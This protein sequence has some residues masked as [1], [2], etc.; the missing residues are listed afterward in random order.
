VKHML[1]TLLLMASLPFA[2]CPAH[3]AQPGATLAQPAPTAEPPAAQAGEAQ[4]WKG[5]LE[6]PGMKLEFIALLTPAHA[7]SPASGTLDIPMQGLKDGPLSEVVVTG[8]RIAFVLALPQMPPQN[9]ARFTA[10]P[11][12]DGLSARGELRQSGGVFPVSLTRIAADAQVGPVRPQEPKPPFPYAQRDVTYINAKDGTTLAGTLT[13]PPGDGPHPAVILITGS[14]PQDRDETIFGHKPFWVLA[15]HLSRQGI[16]VLRV[17]DR[18]VGGSSG[19]TMDSTADD[20][21]GDVLAAVALLRKQPEIDAKRIGV[22]GHS[23]GGLV[24]PI[25]ASQ[26]ADIAFVVMLA[27]TGIKGRDILTLQ[28]GTIMRASGIAQEQVLAVT[29]KHRALMDLLEQQAPREEIIAATKALINS[30][31]QAGGAGPMSDAELAAMAEQAVASMENTWFRAFLTLDPREALRRV[32]VP[33]LALNGALDTQVPPAENLSEIEKAL[34]E[35][36][37]K[38][39][40]IRELPGLNHLF[41]TAQSGSPA[42]YAMIEET[43]APTALDEIAQWIRARTGLDK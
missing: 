32:K 13:I 29:A 14:G 2:I 7:D 18:G 36:G 40:T 8:E 30:Q 15:D 12:P 43:F 6:L 31:R 41:Q 42:E 22:V 27:G 10:T 3:A 21:A 39:V 1:P 16:A 25:A 35:A 26:S 38:D 11:A 28:S 4:R 9:H 17:D 33:V 37:N 20:F 5:E 23:E 19:S 34:R 24:G